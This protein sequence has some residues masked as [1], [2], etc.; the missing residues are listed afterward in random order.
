MSFTERIIF[1]SS[2]IVQ[3]DENPSLSSDGIVWGSNF[4]KKNKNKKKKEKKIF[5]LHTFTVSDY[6]MINH[7]LSTY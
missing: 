6:Q 5:Y 3:K 4:V 2:K 1:Y 7:K